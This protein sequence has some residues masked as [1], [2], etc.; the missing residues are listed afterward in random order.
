MSRR[1]VSS[2]VLEVR[3]RG[4]VYQ[5]SR[6]KAWIPTERAYGRFRIDVPGKTSQREVRLALGFCRD[7]VSAMLK[8][9]EHMDEAGVLDLGTI[10]ERISLFT[11][12]RSQSVW[13]LSEMKAGRIVGKKTREQIRYPT[14]GGYST[15]A[16]YLC[17]VIGEM[18]LASLENDQAKDL[19]VKMKAEQNATGERR[20]GDKTICEYFKVFTQV[21]ASAKE[22]GNELFPRKW[23]LA[24]I[25]LPHIKK[26]NQKRPTI[27]R[28]ELEILLSK[29]KR[30]IYTMIASL[31][32]GSGLRI[33]ELLSLDVRKHISAD[34]KV[35]TIKCQRGQKGTIEVPKTDAGYRTID[36]CEPLANML[37]KFIGDRKD[38][39][40][41]Q[42]GNGTMLSPENLW[43][44]GFRTVVR[45][46]GLDIR[47]HAF[48]RYRESVLQ[49][50][51][52]RD[53]LLHFWMGHGDESLSTRYG[54]QLVR[55]RAFRQEQTN[56]VGLGFDI[57]ISVLIGIR[58]IRNQEQ[59]VAA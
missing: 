1:L 16:A 57:P 46:M 31:L 44:H 39:F 30:P 4:H 51:E 14:I 38:G 13:W 48:R 52:P 56:K 3:Q 22:N 26:R 29:L 18:S 43:K 7:K 34:C 49:A 33:S 2:P 42:T 40:L 41:F 53:M 54:E 21:I 17:D 11:T 37:G 6:S 45:G 27:E 15:A 58:G 12:F 25:G 24:D 59:S 9:R 28:E 32:A 55:D 50:S 20:F 47:F 10:R 8:L 35:I 23:N 5:K 19:I 36:L